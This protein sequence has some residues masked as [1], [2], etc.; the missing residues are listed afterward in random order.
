[1]K[2]HR[3]PKDAA[4]MERNETGI[5]RAPESPRKPAE[6]K[7]ADKPERPADKQN[8]KGGEKKE[9]A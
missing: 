2:I 3:A 4:I 1:M 8:F 7:K 9:E 5:V 6:K